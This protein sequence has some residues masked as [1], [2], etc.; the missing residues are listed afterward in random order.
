MENDGKPG[1]LIKL[2]RKLQKIQE[3]SMKNS[4]KLEV[5]KSFL[6]NYSE[7]TTGFQ[8]KFSARFHHFEQL[9]SG[10]SFHT[11][12]REPDNSPLENS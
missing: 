5:F 8:T 4:E 6:S 11:N 1:S 2:M 9:L 7:L 12:T 10:I 3:D